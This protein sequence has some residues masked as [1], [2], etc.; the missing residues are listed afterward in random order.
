MGFERNIKTSFS[1]EDIKN[2]I[3]GKGDMYMKNSRKEIAKQMVLNHIEKMKDEWCVEGIAACLEVVK[4]LDKKNPVVRI[5]NNDYAVYDGTDC[6]NYD[7]PIN[8]EF[9]IDT[10]LLIDEILENCEYLLNAVW[11][12]PAIE[13]A[14]LDIYLLL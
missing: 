14:R 12:V 6:G 1:I 2:G 10:E 7:Y 3:E 11:S 9:R 4:L 5:P 13:E 8:T